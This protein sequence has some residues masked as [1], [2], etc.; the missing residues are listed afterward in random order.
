M[1]NINYEKKRIQLCGFNVF[2]VA[3]RLLVE[4]SRGVNAA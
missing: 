1:K 4:F 2:N 3:D